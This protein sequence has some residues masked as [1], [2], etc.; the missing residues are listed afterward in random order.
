MS[1]ESVSR[2]DQRRRGYGRSRPIL[3]QKSPRR[4]CRIKIRNNRIGVN[5]F[6]NQPCTL[7]PDLESI[8]RTRMRKIV[9]QHN[10]PEAEISPILVE[11]RPAFVGSWSE[12]R[13]RSRYHC[14]DPANYL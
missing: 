6:L 12:P 5:G 4:S 3:L 11:S 8:L 10:R 1:S 13:V 14:P 2:P 7:I 9:L